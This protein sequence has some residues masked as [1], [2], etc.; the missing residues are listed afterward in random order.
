M[1]T[2]IGAAGAEQAAATLTPGVAVIVPSLMERDVQRRLDAEEAEQRRNELGEEMPEVHGDGDDAVPDGGVPLLV[3]G[4]QVH[5]VPRLGPS[6]GLQAPLPMA[7]EVRPRSTAADWPAGPAVPVAEPRSGIEPGFKHKRMPTLALLRNNKDKFES[8][9][10]ARVTATW[11]QAPTSKTRRT[12]EIED[13]T[14]TP[15]SLDGTAVTLKT[16]STRCRTARCFAAFLGRTICLVDG[17]PTPTQKERDR[18]VRRVF[19]CLNPDTRFYLSAFLEARRRGYAVAGSTMPITV[20]TLEDYSSALV[21]LFG[22]ALEE[23]TTDGPKLVPGCQERASEWRAKGAAELE[24][25]A[26]IRED[27][28]TMIGNPMHT[29]ALKR[30]KTAAEKDARLNGEQSVTSAPVTSD[31][32]KRLYA[33]LV[34]KYL[35]GAS[36]G[37]GGGAIASGGGGPETGAPRDGGTRALPSA[38]GAPSPVDNHRLPSTLAKCDFVVYCLYAFAWVTLA[39]PLSLISMCHGDMSLPDLRLPIN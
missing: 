36:P 39:R 35:P 33:E 27:P 21:F 29:D 34:M 2:S 3:A 8:A 25:E 37:G 1:G 28:G 24:A 14:S 26:L 12:A 23:G 22:E 38:G 32:V 13:E 18:R 9:W 15:A 17:E 19:Q 10:M 4:A 16:W 6:A 5:A 31:M 20:L 11:P 7:D 30:Y